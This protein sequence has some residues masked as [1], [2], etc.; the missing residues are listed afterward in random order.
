MDTP[1][2]GRE[3]K[4]KIVSASLTVTPEIATNANKPVSNLSR[5]IPSTNSE[6]I[7]PLQ[8]IKFAF[9]IEDVMRISSVSS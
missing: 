4:L 3:S 6:L 2:Q 5:V 9:A 7:N 8:R 1:N